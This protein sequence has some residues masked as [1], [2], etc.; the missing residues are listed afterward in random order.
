VRI[1]DAVAS[2]MPP[3]PSVITSGPCALALGVRAWR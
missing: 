1:P 3:Q 2:N